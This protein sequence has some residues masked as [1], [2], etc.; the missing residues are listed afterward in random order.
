MPRAT[1]DTTATER[2]ELD[3]LPATQDDEA[4]WVE[5]KKLSYGQILARRD[6]ATQMSIGGIDN[7]SKDDDISAAI[8]I[9]QK[10]VTEFEF[11]YCIVNHNLDDSNGNKLNFSNPQS[12]TDLDPIIGQEIAELIDDLNKWDADLQGKD[13]PIFEPE[14]EL[15]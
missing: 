10:A 6:M 15:V 4:G 11:K 8:D 7:K 1:I 14:S 3:S 2:F 5:L 12:V 9:I 13:E